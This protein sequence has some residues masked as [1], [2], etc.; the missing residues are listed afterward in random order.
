MFKARR[1]PETS[2]SSSCHCQELA[3]DIA[4]VEALVCNENLQSSHRQ[5]LKSLVT[6]LRTILVVMA[7]D[8]EA[9]ADAL[10]G[11]S[12]K[13][14]EESAFLVVYDRSTARALEI[15]SGRGAELLSEWRRLDVQHR[16]NEDMEIVLLASESREALLQTHGRYFRAAPDLAGD[17]TEPMEF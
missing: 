17:G 5:K 15:R 12:Q 11:L 4:E 13:D 9:Q 8:G 7:A 1:S 3:E 16:T 2:C 6:S 10:T 14:M